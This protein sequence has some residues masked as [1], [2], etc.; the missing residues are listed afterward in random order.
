LK[1]AVREAGIPK[2]ASAH[3]LRHSYASHLLQA[4]CGIRTIQQL[5]GHSSVKTTM[6][7]IHTVPSVTVKD[8]GSPLDL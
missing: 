3:T 7:H 6:I 2:R 4:N 5:L 8:A 1:A